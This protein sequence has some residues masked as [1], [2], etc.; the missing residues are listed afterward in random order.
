MTTSGNLP[1]RTQCPTYQEY[2]DSLAAASQAETEAAAAEEERKATAADNQAKA[3]ASQAT[4][5]AS[6]IMILQS[7]KDV[8]P[9]PSMWAFVNWIQ[10]IR[11]MALLQTNIT[12]AFADFL[13][14]DMQMFSLQLPVVV[15]MGQ[16]VDIQLNDWLGTPDLGVSSTFQSQT[17]SYDFEVGH[18]PSFLA[19]MFITLLM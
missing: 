16:Q 6:F 12:K 2:M 3:G 8:N 17:E 19:T 1:P 11:P 14:E 4:N 5:A 7:V 15:N 9:S 10:I 18:F 13:N